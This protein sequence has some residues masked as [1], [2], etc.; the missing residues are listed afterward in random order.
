MFNTLKIKNDEVIITQNSPVE[1]DSTGI[2]QVITTHYHA[3]CEW[4][5]ID[6]CVESQ[7]YFFGVFIVPII[8]FVTVYVIGGI[9]YGF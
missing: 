9:C 6:G 8:L 5:G 3:V 1:K 7:I 2:K 4:F